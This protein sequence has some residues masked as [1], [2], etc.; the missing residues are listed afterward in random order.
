MNASSW[1]RRLWRQY[2]ARAGLFAVVLWLLALP[3][4]FACSTPAPPKAGTARVAA[5]QDSGDSEAAIALSAYLFDGDLYLST[6]TAEG[7]VHGLARGGASSA[8]EQPI[9]VVEAI[10]A[11]QWLRNADRGRS[12]PVFEPSRW[13]ELVKVLRALG[14]PSEP[15]YGAVIDVFGE[16][17]LFSYYDE[18]GT[19]RTVPI[20]YKPE[21]VRVLSTHRLDDAI[22]S[23][24]PAAQSLQNTSLGGRL[25]ARHCIRVADQTEGV[26]RFIDHDQAA[27]PGFEEAGDHIPQLRIFL[28]RG[29]FRDHDVTQ[30]SR[31]ARRGC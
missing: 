16:Q 30:C 19:L 29:N 13:Y 5:E 24:L 11:D 28:N 15:G 27:G 18:L 1:A 26:T 9:V 6:R 2:R 8:G 25:Y 4:W 3:L 14:T 21:S 12:V 7:D 20:V 31:G 17:D 23:I 10:A 22:R